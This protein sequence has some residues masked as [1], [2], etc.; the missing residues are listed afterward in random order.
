[1]EWA[2]NDSDVYDYLVQAVTGG[3]HP[4]EIKKKTVPALA[5]ALESLVKARAR[6]HGIDDYWIDLRE[7]AIS[8]VDWRA[9]AREWAGFPG[10]PKVKKLEPHLG[11][12]NQP[13][14]LVYSMFA[15]KPELQQ[16]LE[17]AI[18]GILFHMSM[19]THDVQ[20]VS[21]YVGRRLEGWIQSALLEMIQT[22]K[23]A[24]AEPIP[25]LLAAVVRHVDYYNLANIWME[26][27]A[28]ISP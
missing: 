21:G 19:E 4:G 13:T 5:Q 7:A 25:S 14:W 24:L 10:K 15:G 18:A 2:S 22:M 9:A 17:T 16:Q 11:F 27:Y 3:K 12:G 28:G 8:R 26:A 23:P 20:S 1:V 6:M